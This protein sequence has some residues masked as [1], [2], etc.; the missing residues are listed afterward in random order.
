ML[1]IGSYSWRENEGKDR[2]HLAMDMY[3]QGNYED[4]FIYVGLTFITFWILTSYMVPIS[5][6]VTMEIVKFWQA[7]MFINNDPSMADENNPDDHAQ[8]RNSNLNEDLGK[9]EYVFSDKTG[10]LTSNDMQLRLVN[11]KGNSYGHVDF[12]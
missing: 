2:H 11:I 9:V 5:L 6:F 3:V 8:A 4:G 12:K 7:F 1:A 10:T